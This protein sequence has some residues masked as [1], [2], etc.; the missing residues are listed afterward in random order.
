M[1]N[2]YDNNI[3]EKD[4]VVVYLEAFVSNDGT[5]LSNQVLTKFQAQKDYII[6]Q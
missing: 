2:Y 1:I 3:D 5:A 6:A 4:N